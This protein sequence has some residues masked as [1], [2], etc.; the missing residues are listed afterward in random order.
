M[1]ND[2]DGKTTYNSSEIVGSPIINV[3]GSFAELQLMIDITPEN[4]V[5]YLPNKKYTAIANDITIY[6]NEN[7][8]WCDCESY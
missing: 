3:T 1:A 6:N 5:L 4:G 2:Y 8:I 7:R